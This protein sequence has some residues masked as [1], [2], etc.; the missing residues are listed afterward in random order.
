MGQIYIHRLFTARAV[1]LYCAAAI[2][3]GREEAATLFV[4]FRDSLRV[5]VAMTSK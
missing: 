2:D 4:V 3:I 1:V 5:V